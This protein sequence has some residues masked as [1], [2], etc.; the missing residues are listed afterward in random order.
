MIRKG[1]VTRLKETLAEREQEIKEVK[2]KYLRA[3]AELEN[4][5]KRMER[6]FEEF[7]K[8]ANLEFF[9]KVISVLDN[10]DRALSGAELSGNFESFYKGMEIIYRQLKDTLQ[11]LGLTEFS[12]LGETFDPARHEAVAV[13]PNSD[14]PDNTIIEEI[15]KG[16]MVGERIIKPA[17]VLVSRQ[18]E[19]GE[20]N[21]KNNRD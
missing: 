21:G 11:S 7:K 4:Y 18:K 17:Q 8:Y 15:S 1:P 12:G 6:E 13:I 19:G 3:L 16:Y 14:K 5:R 2:D 9:M 20:E 10:F